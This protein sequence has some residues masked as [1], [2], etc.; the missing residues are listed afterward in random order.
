MRGLKAEFLF[1]LCQKR[2]WG[3]TRFDY[4]GHGES[5]ALAENCSPKDWLADTLAV[6]DHLPNKLV[7]IGSSMGAWLAINALRQQ[8][9]KIQAI[10]TIA[11]A[12]DFP[13][14]LLWP[15]LSRSQQKAIKAGQCITRETPYDNEPW[16]IKKRLFDNANEL[17]LLDKSSTLTMQIPVRMLHGTADNDVPWSFS[18]RLLEKFVY[19][20]NATLTL[21][22]G[23]DHRLSEPQHLTI[24]KEQLECL[25]ESST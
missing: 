5:N 1:K 17:S 15:A 21:L 22:R 4:R 14:L 13:E 23:A 11:A 3:F 25:I 18:Q 9:E 20:S 6:I 2:G 19:S 8:E 7:V 16:R 12:P 24:L 10:L